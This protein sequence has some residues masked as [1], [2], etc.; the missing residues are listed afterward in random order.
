MDIVYKVKEDIDQNKFGEIG[1]EMVPSPEMQIVKIVEFDYDSELVQ[2]KIKNLYGN[3][4]WKERFYNGDGRK[5]L[6]RRLGLRYN[7]DGTIKKTEKFVEM[8][9]NWVLSIELNGDKM[10]GFS[11][12]D[13]GDS[14]VY[15]AKTLLDK[16][17]NNEIQLLKDHNLIEEA[18]V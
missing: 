3:P 5:I 18:E 8:I 12:L 16:Y 7:P 15:C 11:S 1:Y 17:F 13:S 9:T 4:A 10:V 2:T 6:K 14:S